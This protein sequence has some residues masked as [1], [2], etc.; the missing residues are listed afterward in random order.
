MQT[1]RYARGAPRS[2]IAVVEPTS[3]NTGIG[4]A[5]AA[6]VL[7]SKLVLFV[8]VVFDFRER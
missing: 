7:D 5:Y 1:A 6:V 3:G 8:S 4:G 2:G